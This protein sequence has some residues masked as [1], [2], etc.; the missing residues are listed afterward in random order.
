MSRRSSAAGGSAGI[1]P[2]GVGYRNAVAY[3]EPGKR[4]QSIH[5]GVAFREALAQLLQP[6]F[7]SR[8][9]TTRE[10]QRLRNFLDRLLHVVR[11]IAVP[12]REKELGRFDIL[13]RKLQVRP[14]ALST[15]IQ[16]APAQH[17]RPR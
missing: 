15:L 16:F 9:D 11:G 12:S 10:Q 4:A 2:P 14:D 1:R 13:G 3:A 17:R 5:P 7:D 8:L 6:V